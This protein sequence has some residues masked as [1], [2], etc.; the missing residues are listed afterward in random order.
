MELKQKQED[1]TGEITVRTYRTNFRKMGK[2]NRKEKHI[3]VHSTR[4]ENDNLM[5]VCALCRCG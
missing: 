3:D 4:I 2:E 5:V 1:E